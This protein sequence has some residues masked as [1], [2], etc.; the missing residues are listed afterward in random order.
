[1]ECAGPNPGSR[2]DP[3]FRAHLGLQVL[4]GE[5]LALG[6]AIVA[7]QLERSRARG[8]RT[9]SETR[10][11]RGPG[12]S[13]APW[14][15]RGRCGGVLAPACRRAPESAGDTRRALPEKPDA[16]KGPESRRIHR[17]VTEPRT[18]ARRRPLQQTAS[19]VRESPE[20]PPTPGGYPVALLLDMQAAQLG[21]Q[22]ARSD[23]EDRPSA[24]ADPGEPRDDRGSG[25][26]G[27][28]DAPA[29]DRVPRLRGVARSA[30]G[31]TGRRRTRAA[32]TRQKR[33]AVSSG[34]SSPQNP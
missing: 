25:N 15:P 14:R 29:D 31:R 22:I 16:G 6:V 13:P 17:M 27:S 26:Q 4:G 9:G 23:G 5:L 10:K 21:R 28:G 12:G 34:A 1:M 30:E 20:R 7:G 24:G 2:I 33:A 11:G 19:S 32:G 18:G 3:Y 8:G